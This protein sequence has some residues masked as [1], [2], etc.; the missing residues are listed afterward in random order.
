M[1]LRR[2]LKCP[3]CGLHL[4]TKNLNYSQPFLC[5]HCQRELKVSRTYSTFFGLLGL[6]ISYVIMFK[7][8]L[9]DFS[10]LAA[11]FVGWFPVLFIELRTLFRLFPPEPVPVD[12]RLIR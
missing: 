7:I 10:L 4:Q 3:C 6:A 5:P 1:I 11:G 8:G 2:P 12:E 9:R